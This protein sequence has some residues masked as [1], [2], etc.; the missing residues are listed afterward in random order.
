MPAAPVAGVSTISARVGAIRSTFVPARARDAGPAELGSAAAFDAFGD[1]YQQALAGSPSTPADS[2]TPRTATTAA[3]MAAT[4]AARATA[5]SYG[6]ATW[7]MSTAGAPAAALSPAE[8]P[9]GAGPTADQIAAAIAGAAGPPGVRPIGGYGPMPVPAE[10]AGYGNGQIPAAA[11]TPLASQ[12]HHQHAAP[13][14]AAWDAA[15]AAAAA[16]GIKLRITDSYRSYDQQVDL[17]QRKGLHSQGGLA[18]TPGTSNHGWGLAVD[19][20]V[21]DRATY[22]WLSVNGARFGWVE[23]VGREPWHWEFRPNQV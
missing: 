1:V 21:T 22:N 19:A 14:A 23:A 2:F 17:A 7:M 11:L 3:T 20:D 8:R 5:A 9:A 15:V 6:Q 10:L 12:P 16:D 4:T 13:A 18:A